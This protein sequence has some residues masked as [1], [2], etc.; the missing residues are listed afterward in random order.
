MNNNFINRI[1]D[2]ISKTYQEIK[3]IYIHQSF[4]EKYIDI[5]I[6][7]KNVF[8]SL[9]FSKY[10]F[11]NSIEDKESGMFVNFLLFDSL[12]AQEYGEKLEC[13]FER[14][15][16]DTL[17]ENDY[18]NIQYQNNYNSFIKHIQKEIYFSEIKF[19]NKQ[20]QQNDLNFIIGAKLSCQTH[21]NQT[22]LI[23]A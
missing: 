17:K 20:I 9:S 3:R 5:M 11:D 13:V 8:N 22:M 21:Q 1:V 15:C 14:N 12:I 19:F 10:I 2:E 6:D 18:T 7:N 16:K 4:K 23:A